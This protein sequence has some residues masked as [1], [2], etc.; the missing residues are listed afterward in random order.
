MSELEARFKK[1]RKRVT[2]ISA[3]C[4]EINLSLKEMRLRTR[5]ILGVI[6]VGTVINVTL[7]LI[8]L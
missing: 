1:I 8:F 2:E 5:K 7:I 4:D 3:T 6:L